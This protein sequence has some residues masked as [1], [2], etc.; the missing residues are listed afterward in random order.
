MTLSIKKCV[1][2]VGMILLAVTVTLILLF[3]FFTVPGISVNSFGNDKIAHSMAYTALGFSLFLSLVN[4]PSFMERRKER[5]RGDGRLRVLTYTTGTIVRSLAA[6]TL[7]G[8]AIEL[9]QP[10]FGR[11]FEL[12]DL[13]ADFLGLV[14]GTAFGI[15][16][17]DLFLSLVMD[18]TLW[19]NDAHETEK[20]HRE[21]TYVGSEDSSSRG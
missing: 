18:K 11:S 4:L 12:L 16:L 20:E 6:G 13:C 5:K 7:L 19:Y 14:L 8:L 10:F 21:R 3:S 17:L 1:R 9:I 2:A 15:L